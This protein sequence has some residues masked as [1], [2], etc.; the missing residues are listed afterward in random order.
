MFLCKERKNLREKIYFIDI[1]RNA[2]FGSAKLQIDFKKKI[3]LSLLLFK[4]F[5]SLDFEFM[6]LKQ[7]LRQ[8][9]DSFK[10]VER[11]FDNTL[12]LEKCI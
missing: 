8:K 7:K 11:L 6:C 3:I 5:I 1:L 12:G 4:L 9:I 2:S 10:S